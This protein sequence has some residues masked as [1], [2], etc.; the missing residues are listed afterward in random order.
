MRKTKIVCTIG[1]ASETPEI[2]DALI[3]AGMNVARL[4][5]SHGTQDEH[6]QRIDAIREASKRVGKPVG[7]LLDTRGPEIRT[8][9]MRGDGILLTKDH[10]ID[11]KMEEVLGT[12]EAFSV[13][14][15]KLI[16]DVEVGSSILLDDGLIHLEVTG[17][18]YENRTIHTVALNAG[19]LKSKKGVN[20][21]GVS[22]QLPG[23]TEKDRSDILFGVR[24]GVDFIAPSF[25]RRPE[26]VIEIRTLLDEN[27]GEDIHI[28]PKIENEEGVENIDEIL[29]I[30]DGMMVARGDLGVEIKA[31][32]VPLVQK[33]LI[34]SCNQAGKPVITA[35]QMLDSMQW[36]PRPT[37]AEA[38]DVANAIF[39]GSDAIMLSGE[40][41]AGSYPVEAVRMM[42]NIARTTENAVDYRAV[43]ATRRREQH[44]NMTESI[45]QAAS[46]AALNL[47]VSA[48][49][50]PT[51]SGQ[52]ARMIAKYR[53][54]CPVI[55]VTANE[56][57]TTKL[58]LAWGVYPIM[59]KKA[60]SID[61]ILQE[62]VDLSLEHEYVSRGDVVIITAGVPVGQAGTTN[63]MKIHVIGDLIARGKGIGKASVYGRA[64]VANKAEDLQGVNLDGAIIVTNNTDKEMMPALERC[65]GLIMEEGGLTSHGAIVGLSL[66]I[67][68]IIG[69]P[70]ATDVITDD[71]PITM[72][73]ESGC[74]YSGHAKVL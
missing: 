4:N 45:G 29:K 68:V 17:L 1:P 19:M 3:H 7:I 55:A 34:K 43:V 5:F 33:H 2:L 49:L 15:D 14:Y 71:T 37:R 39:D 20:V 60:M 40:T 70:K 63:L 69:V 59:G 32:E 56:S 46:Y 30:S 44:G 36:N 24:E 62:A 50:A 6:K 66:G 28:I 21:P 53:P 23:M 38:S 72:H 16:E 58:T 51:E 74:I 42:D 64:I 26:D 22:V 57:V 8:H 47:N 9:N 52:T 12:E 35:T 31:E 67:P 54:G 27:Q 65:A 13:T 73:A 25:I 10:T 48:V 41:A 61:G 11:I 18:D